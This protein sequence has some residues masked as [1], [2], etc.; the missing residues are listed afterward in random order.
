M[1]KFHLVVLVAAAALTGCSR[2]TQADKSGAAG[3]ATESVMVEAAVG[4]FVTLENSAYEAWK[5]KDA[6]FWDTFLTDG[7]V[8]YGSAGSWTR[9]QRHGSTPAPTASSRATPC[10]TCR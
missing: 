3:T 10:P 2:K 4:A 8:G 7:F 6:K 5:S 1:A 9:N